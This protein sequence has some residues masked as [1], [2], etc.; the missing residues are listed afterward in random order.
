MK[1]Q[2]TPRPWNVEN[3]VNIQDSNFYGIAHTRVDSKLSVHEQ[4]ANAE[5]IVRAVN[6]YDELIEILNN[7]LEAI[8]QVDTTNNNTRVTE[9]LGIAETKANDLLRRAKGSL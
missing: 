6:S 5:L 1:T 9:E 8:S 7:L 3:G 2:A 4:T